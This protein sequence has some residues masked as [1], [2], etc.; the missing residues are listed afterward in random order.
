VQG[1]MNLPQKKRASPPQYVSPSQWVLPGFE[2]PFSQKL[3][4]N[5]RWVLL[6]KRIPW[7]K[8]ASVYNRRMS[9]SSEGRPSLS[10]RLVLGALF[11]KHLN[12]WDDRETILQIQE[13]MYLQYFVGYSSFTTDTAFDPSLFVEIRKRMGDTEL[14]E[15]NEELVKLHLSATKPPVLEVRV[16][17]KPTEKENDKNDKKEDGQPFSDLEPPKEAPTKENIGPETA[18][19]TTLHYGRM[20]TDATACPQDIAFPTDV[21][22]LSD[23]REKSEYLIDILYKLDIHEKK[24]PRTYRETARKAYLN[25]AKNRNNSRK[26]IRKAIGIQLNF[27]KRNLK[28]VHLLLD[29]YDKKKLNYPLEKKEMRY[30]WIIQTLYAQQHQMHKSYTHSVADRIVSIHQPHVRPIVRGKVKDKVEF[31]AKINVT[32]ANGFAFLDDL[33]WDAFNEGTRLIKYVEQYHTRFGYYPKEILADQIYCNRENRKQ[34]KLLNIKLLAKP[35]GRP[36]LGA[37]KEYVR[38]GERN[39]IE[40]KFGQGKNAYGLGKIKARLKDTSQSWIA[41]I[42]LILNL[43]KLAGLNLY[44]LLFTVEQKIMQAFCLRKNI[45][46]NYIG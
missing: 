5:N 44:C 31:G 32:I 11:I 25:V 2:T 45:K 37:I 42:I 43:V 35:L 41:S 27:L 3:D 10:A 15:I 46:L 28:N 34:L 19:E 9:A 23:A 24:K 30:F 38:P 14:N 7:D 26:A 8:I 39:P 4:P 21:N 33:C 17:S 6:S 12:N 29:G 18:A 16:V 22:L 13:N 36:S 1:K 20:I 40:G